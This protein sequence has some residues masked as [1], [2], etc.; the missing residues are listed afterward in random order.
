MWSFSKRKSEKETEEKKKAN[1]LE[2]NFE[3][4]LD[5]IRSIKKTKKEYQDLFDKISLIVDISSQFRVR[6]LD[7][8]NEFVY[9]KRDSHKLI[10]HRNQEKSIHQLTLEDIKRYPLDL[11]KRSFIAWAEKN[12][13]FGYTSLVGE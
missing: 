4:T 3:K 7:R 5:T 6:L 2:K 9:F 11:I 12:Y 10:M 8:E 13:G 1:R